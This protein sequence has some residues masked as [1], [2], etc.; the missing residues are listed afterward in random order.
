MRLVLISPSLPRAA[1][2]SA[3]AAV[4]A[5]GV[6]LGACSSANQAQYQNAAYAGVQPQVPAPAKQ[7]AY[8]A[9]P[10]DPIKDA[11][12]EPRRAPGAQPDDPNEPFSPNY[13][14]QRS[15]PKVTVS[16][17]EV[18]T[19]DPEPDQQPASMRLPA[20]SRA[21]FKKVTTTAAAD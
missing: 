5:I 14:G 20:P 21:Y 19:H 3:V 9:A 1:R 8:E 10:G 11:P 6:A 12:I 13:G 17:Y 4:V 18:K 7:A 2:T 16:D 15:T